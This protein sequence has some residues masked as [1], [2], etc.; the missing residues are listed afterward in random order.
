MRRTILTIFFVIIFL[1]IP[2]RKSQCNATNVNWSSLQ[3]AFKHYADYPSPENAS[4][5]IELLPVD[6]VSYT[7]SKQEKD[8]F[9]FM[10]GVKS[11]LDS[12]FQFFQIQLWPDLLEY[13]IPTHGTML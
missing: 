2:L 5:V 1:C 3:E 12:S 7:G 9:D 4:K 10:N 8:A 6:H 13:S 11:A